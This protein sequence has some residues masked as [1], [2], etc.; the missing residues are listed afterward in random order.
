MTGKQARL[1][2][3]GAERLLGAID[4]EMLFDAFVDA[5]RSV[6]CLDATHAVGVVLERAAFVGGWSPELHAAVVAKDAN[7]LNSVAIDLCEL[8]VLGA[9]RRS[10]GEHH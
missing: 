2:K 7:A 5:A 3:V 1:T 6:L 4:T 9:E 8:R 10:V